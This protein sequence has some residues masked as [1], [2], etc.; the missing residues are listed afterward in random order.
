M[1]LSIVMTTYNRKALIGEALDSALSWLDGPA[2]TEIVVV[3]D[4]STDGTE[5]YL[6]SRYSELIDNNRLH[7]VILGRNLGM[8]GAR[9]IGVLTAAG[10][11]IVILDSDDVLLPNS[12][13]TVVSAIEAHGNY[14]WLCFRCLQLENGKLIGA[15]VT[16]PTEVNAR[17]FLRRWRFSE[18][19]PVVRREALLEI[20]FDEDDFVGFTMVKIIQRYGPL[21]VLKEPTRGYRVSNDDR[22]T[23][24]RLSTRACQ[25]ARGHGRMLLY[26]PRD[27]GLRAGLLTLAKIVLY[28]LCCSLNKLRIGRQRRLS[29]S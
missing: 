9:N 23:K 25:M 22:L 14:A 3:D 10:D 27:Y 28:A 6:K 7:L 4:G 20:P 11:W 19:M 2:S 13:S 8:S 24:A 16:G 15:P 1:Q 26:M 21:L 18:C 17:D 12:Q 29:E 5:A